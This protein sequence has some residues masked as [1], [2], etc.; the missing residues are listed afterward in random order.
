MKL[1]ILKLCP[2]AARTLGVAP[3]WFAQAVRGLDASGSGDGAAAT[4]AATSADDNGSSS[5]SEEE[6]I[7][8]WQ[9]RQ[10]QQQQE[11]SNPIVAPWETGKA[12]RG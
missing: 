8:L 1:F 7:E 9:Q 10:Q 3:Y 4:P 11:T 5:S 2:P 12:G 6:D